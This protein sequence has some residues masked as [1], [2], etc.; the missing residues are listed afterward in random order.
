MAL[1]RS[2]TLNSGSKIPA[3]GFGTWLAAPHEVETAVE[4]ALRAG[5]RHIDGAAIYRNEAEVGSG[6]KKSGVPR[7][8]IFLTTKLW[9]TKHAPSDVEAALDESLKLLGTDY[10]DLYL[11]HWP[12]AFE[13]V[14]K[15][16]PLT[17]EGYFKV[18]DV[19][20]VDTWK[21]MEKLLKTGKTKAIG[22]S[23]FN[24]AKLEKL[25]AECEV[26]PAVNQIEAHPYL[27]QKE[28]TDYCRQKGIL[29]EAYSPLGNNLLGLPKA[30][31]DEVVIEVGKKLD[32]DP[33]QV[34]ISWAVQRETVVLPKSVTEKR[35]ISNFQDKELPEWA[36][37]E[38]DALEKHKRLN[39]PA[40]WGVD[41]F[42]EIG[43]EKAKK[44][45]DDAK[46]KN[47]EQFKV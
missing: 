16:F 42:E 14:G 19:S 34:L 38:L 30:T 46:E 20:P 31:D 12:V 36:I 21:A 23:N 29:I 4:I 3:V 37:K 39:F 17:E 8:D 43:L 1:N 13:N 41:I 10:V 45:A 25:L 32:M 26:V 9:N 33:G 35:I 27:Q 11:M 47:L 7:E 40:R 6:I 44:N 18:A 2:F 24:K 22:V 15:W 28:L 5:Y